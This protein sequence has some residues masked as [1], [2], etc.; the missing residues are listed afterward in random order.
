MRS[1][2]WRCVKVG[3][4]TVSLACVHIICMCSRKMRIT[5]TMTI[6]SNKH[7]LW[8]AF[9]CVISILSATVLCVNNFGSMYNANII[10]RMMM[11]ITRYR[12][13]NVRHASVSNN[14]QTTNNQWC[15]VKPS[16]C[17]LVIVKW[18]HAALQKTRL[19]STI[20]IMFTHCLVNKV[21][22]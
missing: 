19:C 10:V 7:I 12:T 13:S 21:V 2:P 6:N 11:H 14:D 4:P 18:S 5:I 15:I 8:W 1:E 16:P 22:R 17:G 9:V 20:I 3:L